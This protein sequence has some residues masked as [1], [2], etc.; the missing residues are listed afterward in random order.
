[1]D[2]EHGSERRRL[3]P[4]QEEVLA[5]GLLE[6]GFNC[7]LQM[8]TGSG[9]TCLAEP[10]IG[11]VLARAQ[12]GALLEGP[13]SRFRRLTPFAQI[14]ALSA[15]SGN[16]RELADWLDGVEYGSTWRPIPLRW[17]VVR[18]KNASDKPRLLTEEVSATAQ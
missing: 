17:R 3:T 2:I 11:K 7:I 12:G 1:M 9:K 16:R 6:S 13:L 10:T 4:P 8:P 18:Y 14:L 15:T 5:S